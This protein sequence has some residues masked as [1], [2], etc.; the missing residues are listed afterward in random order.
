MLHRHV[1]NGNAESFGEV[2]EVAAGSSRSEQQY[3]ASRHDRGPDEALRARL[4][5]IAIDDDETRAHAK[6]RVSRWF[7]CLWKVGIVSRQFDGGAEQR[8]R[9]RV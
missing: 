6:Q 4:V 8:S 1:H 2:T 7:T 5:V 9:E 3:L